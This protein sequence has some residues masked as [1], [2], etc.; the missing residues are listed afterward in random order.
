MRD[1]L[2]ILGGLPNDLVEDIVL[3]EG[4]AGPRNTRTR[5]IINDVAQLL[6]GDGSISFYSE[7]GIA[8]LIGEINQGRDDAR[9]RNF[10]AQTV[11]VYLDSRLVS[12]FAPP[13][14]PQSFT[15][16]IESYY[17]ISPETIL[18]FA[19]IR[20]TADYSSQSKAISLRERLQD[21]SPYKLSGGMDL[22]FFEKR[23]YSQLLNRAQEDT[24]PLENDFNEN[25]SFVAEPLD[26]ANVLQIF[27]DDKPYA[28]LPGETPKSLSTI[29]DILGGLPTNLA[30]EFVYFEGRQR[31]RF[32]GV[33]SF[34]SAETE[35]FEDDV[36]I[37]LFTDLGLNSLISQINTRQIDLT[38]HDIIKQSTSIYVDDR[39]VALLDGSN[40]QM[41]RAKISEI[42]QFYT[43]I[44]PLFGTISEF[45]QT[46]ASYRTKV[47][48]L[49]Q[50]YRGEITVKNNQR[51]DLLT[52]T[53]VKQ[54]SEADNAEAALEN[55][56]QDEDTVL[57]DLRLPPTIS[58]QLLENNSR[59]IGGAIA[60]PG[61][62]P[63]SG[64]IDLES[65][66]QVAG[67]FARGAD[68]TSIRVQELI[69]KDGVLEF[70]RETVHDISR[71][72]MSQVALSGEYLVEVTPLINDAIAGTVQID[73]EVRRPGTYSFN[74]SETLHDLLEKAG[75]LSDVAY[76]LGA[77]FERNSI[78]DQQRA[79]N[80]L[81]AGQLEQSILQLS[82]SD[83]QDA[84]ATMSAVNGYAEQ[85]R[86]MTP[87]GRLAVNL[88]LRDPSVPVF[89][90]D[91]DKL[92]V[93]KRPSHVFVI[94][95][96]QNTTRAMYAPEKSLSQYIENAGGYNRIA[97][98]RN[99]YLLLPNGES[100]ALG[101]DTLIPPGS[102]IVVPP[103]TQKFSVL[104]LTDIVS[105]VLG[106]IA[107]SVLAINNLQ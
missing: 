65:L 49:N 52:R 90:E 28:F 48:N 40:A 102:M 62:Y 42:S 58:K 32:S 63:V 44:Y 16:S 3:F 73:G 82:N 105:R 46:N 51:I 91:G 5:S 30:E 6:E 94:G 20:E 8:R 88:L 99:I 87:D 15:E 17:Q 21:P 61:N 69:Q 95:S 55:L 97:D 13:L 11:N 74:A 98:K 24:A 107:T 64:L 4:K 84:A 77:V 18:D 81:L 43:E 34:R 19:L 67:D 80:K 1:I 10:L 76:P 68:L 39:L 14:E 35:I 100:T 104:G 86:T 33:T 36:A 75:G 27:V 103:N 54:N 37:Y 96:V 50:L 26:D 106:N 83:R 79:S 57:S 93:P 23:F 56:V 92:Y 12:V 71:V 31:A 72:D 101:K 2:N 29:V 7:R 85:L 78:K 70:G 53:M 89:L 41:L 66:I 9:T 25:I 45:D 38:T 47:T 59:Y 60:E 22:F